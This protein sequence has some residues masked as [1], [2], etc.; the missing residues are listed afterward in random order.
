MTS[1]RF[2]N[3][4]APKFNQGDKS[5][6]PLPHTVRSL[7]RT[8]SVTLVDAD[9]FPAETA[10]QRLNDRRQKYVDSLSSDIADPAARE[11]AVQLAER[12][13]DRYANSFVLSLRRVATIDD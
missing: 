8:A 6:L 1:E 2:S 4:E 7:G 13:F 11:Q 9:A 10:S 3:P 5:N 12:A